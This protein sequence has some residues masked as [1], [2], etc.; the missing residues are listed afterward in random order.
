MNKIVLLKNISKQYL[1]VKQSMRTNKKAVSMFKLALVSLICLWVFWFYAYTVTSSSTKWYFLAQKE[2]I[3]KEKEFE[4]SIAKLDILQLEQ[5]LYQSVQDNQSNFWYD[6][7]DE[8]FIEVKTYKE[9]WKDEKMEALR[10]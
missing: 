4:Y 3:K 1:S 10:N 8:R 2:K 9:K 5:K 7:K 6:N